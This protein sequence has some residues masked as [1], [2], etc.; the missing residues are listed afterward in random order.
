MFETMRQTVLPIGVAIAIGVWLGRRRSIDERPLA[1]LGIEVFGPALIL[2]NIPVRLA[3]EPQAVVLLL[4]ATALMLAAGWLGG[5]LL[6]IEGRDERIGF[7]FA[8]AFANFAFFGLPLVEFGLGADAFEWAILNLTVLNI[9]TAL[10]GIYLATP[11]RDPVAALRETARVPFTWAV[12]LAL[13]L[14]F[15]G[16][17]LPGWLVR[18]LDLLGDGAI[19]V[20]L[21]VL[22]IQLGRLRLRQIPAG[23]MTAAVL[24]RLAVAPAVTAGLALLLGQ[25]LSSLAVRSAVLQLA[26]PAGMAP[27]LFLVAF[28]RSSAILSATIFVSTALSM[29]TVP[30]VVVLLRG[31]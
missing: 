17:R 12:L 10:I 11:S 23:P 15:A 31:I 3:A 18:P 22:G 27:F 14:G 19:P 29:L 7:L 25:E 20:M 28:G 30:V 8:V 16:V 1:R 5:R 4:G 24:L 21:V 26:T 13:V 9:P 6:G 2:A